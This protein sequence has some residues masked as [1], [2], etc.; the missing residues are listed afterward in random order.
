MDKEH[1]ALSDENILDYMGE[2]YM[3]GIKENIAEIIKDSYA[4]SVI[5]AL[6]DEAEDEGISS[7]RDMDDDTYF[8]IVNKYEM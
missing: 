5:D 4:H 3:E 1:E 2:K 7:I 8:R 6:R